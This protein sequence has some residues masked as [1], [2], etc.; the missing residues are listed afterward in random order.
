MGTPSV[1]VVAIALS[2]SARVP[3]GGGRVWRK[4]VQDRQRAARR[5]WLGGPDH[6]TIH[7]GSYIASS[8]RMHAR[9]PGSGLFA[10]SLARGAGTSTIN[11]RRQRHHK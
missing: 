7:R 2:P 4:A 8:V 5:S 3:R 10:R 6:P 9:W 1:W 11:Q